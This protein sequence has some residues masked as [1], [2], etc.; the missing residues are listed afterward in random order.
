MK[1]VLF[2]TLEHI[3]GAGGLIALTLASKLIDYILQSIFDR[4][5]FK[6][7][8]DSLKRKYRAW[9]LRREK[10][11]ATFE[12]SV[13]LEEDLPQSDLQGLSDT[14][15]ESVESQSEEDFRV[16]DR[17]W[18]VDRKEILSEVKHAERNEPYRVIL[19]FLPDGEPT[20]ETDEV[21]AQNIGSIGIS[22]KFQFAFGN[23][24]GSI[25][26]LMVLSEF[27]TD[28]IKKQ[29]SHQSVTDGQLIVSS[30]EDDLTLDNWVN[31]EQFDVSLLLHS[32]DGRRSVEF[33]KD[34][35]IIKSPYSMVDQQTVEYIRAVLINYYI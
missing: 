16:V 12:Y 19:S 33:H 32:E 22:I 20:F 8:F 25:I 26:D 6:P 30:L 34:R 7:V 2:I 14:I 10:I 23:I 17:K 15:F 31:T 13:Y 24:R 5:L 9:S 29:V 18:S 3:A 1:T 28:S 27:L 35:A 4:R 11:S 21:P